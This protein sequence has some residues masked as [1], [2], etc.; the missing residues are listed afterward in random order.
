MNPTNAPKKN[1]ATSNALLCQLGILLALS[2]TTASPL[3]AHTTNLIPVLQIKADQVAAHISLMLYGLM[4]EE[5]NYSYD[6]GLYGELVRNRTF[7]ERG[8]N[9]NP[10]HWEL[11]ENGGSGSLSSH[12]TQPPHDAPG[13]SFE[14]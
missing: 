9:A 4:T 14:L 1:L 3:C 2:I 10:P 6:G 11:L 7:K 12:T 5:I 13:A 8:T